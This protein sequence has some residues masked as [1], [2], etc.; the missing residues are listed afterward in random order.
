[1][2]SLLDGV[3]TQVVPIVAFAKGWGLV[4]A[5]GAGLAMT[6][7]WQ[8]WWR[9]D[10]GNTTSLKRGWFDFRVGAALLV[11]FIASLGIFW[12]LMM[13]SGY[14]SIIYRRYGYVPYTLGAMTLV[15]LLTAPVL[16]RKVGTFPGLMVCGTIAWLWLTLNAACLPVIRAQDSAMWSAVAA[17]TTQK[18][19]PAVLFVT[20]WHR[21]EMPG[22]ELENTPGLRGL[23]FPEIFESPLGA[24]WWEAEYPV[25]VLGAHHT[26]YRAIPEPDGRVRV[27]GNMLLR[28]Y[29][30]SIPR[31]SLVV[32]VNPSVT[33]PLWNS[34]LS[35]VRVFASW[36]AFEVA[37][38]RELLGP[39]QTASGK[40]SLIADGD[41]QFFMVDDQGNKIAVTI[42]PSRI[43]IPSHDN[44][45]QVNTERTRIDW[46]NGSV[47]TRTIPAFERNP[48]YQAAAGLLGPWFYGDKRCAIEFS[49]S[50]KRELILVNEHGQHP[51]AT[52]RGRI[53]YADVWRIQG[54]WSADGRTINWS[55]GT[56]WRR[57]SEH[58]AR[59]EPAPRG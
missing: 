46:L 21:P 54:E 4:T 55:N 18:R 8:Y 5:L 17:V 36:D 27:F 58:P 35:Q 22:Y 59:G 42:R 20:D 32:V 7:M 29:P 24:Y 53:I 41:S 48:K 38:E 30:V 10:A 28:I 37:S 14:N 16:R 56:V 40:V 57:R 3:E 2:R 49:G 19:D 34:D 12:L 47:W 45:G 44:E 15:A 50:E 26:G 39:W 11:I 31:E 13:L 6:L 51:L 52:L 1:M 43:Y 33:P 9:D 25:A 23:S